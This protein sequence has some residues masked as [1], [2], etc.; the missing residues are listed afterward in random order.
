MLEL[1]LN[2]EGWVIFE[3]KKIVKPILL[4]LYCKNRELFLEK[5]RIKFQLGKD[6]YGVTENF[7]RIYLEDKDE[8][9]IVINDF[10]LYPN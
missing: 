6:S 1:A 10:Q 7:I 5:F 2:D 3:D 9:H 4:W 8:E